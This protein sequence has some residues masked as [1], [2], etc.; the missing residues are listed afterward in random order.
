MK[1]Y[2]KP[3]QIPSE[4]PFRIRLSDGRT[5]TDPSSFT[6]EEIADAGYAEAPAKPSFVETGKSVVWNYET[7][8]WYAVGKA[9]TEE[10]NTK[11]WYFRN[12]ETQEILLQESQWMATRNFELGIVDEVFDAYRQELENFDLFGD[13]A[14]KQWPQYNPSL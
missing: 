5:R 6:D 3:G 11:H 8:E 7:H 4:L 14:T 9:V 12:K 1:L 13:P 2:Y 10:Q